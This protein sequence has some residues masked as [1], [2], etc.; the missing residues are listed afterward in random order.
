MTP[1][2]PNDRARPRERHAAL[3][4]RLRAA[5]VYPAD[6]VGRPGQRPPRRF[7]ALSGVLG[8]WPG[9]VKQFSKVVPDEFWT[10][11]GLNDEEEL[12]AIV[13]CPCGA[14]PQVIQNRT[15]ICDGDGCGRVF[16]MLGETIRVASYDP[17]DLA[18]DA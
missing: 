12:V 7:S 5:G 2:T 17:A 16:L 8:I 15:T 6:Y 18:P 3:S 4:S 1:P 10:Q 14:E 13:A 9:F 11:V